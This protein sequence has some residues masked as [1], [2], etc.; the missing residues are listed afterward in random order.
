MEM[1]P[2]QTFNIRITFSDP[3][4]LTPEEIARMEHAQTILDREVGRIVSQIKG[5]KDVSK[6]ILKS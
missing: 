3:E 6:K 5:E 4:E 1:K 2:M